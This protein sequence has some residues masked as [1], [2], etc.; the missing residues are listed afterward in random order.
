MNLVYLVIRGV[1]SFLF[2]MVLSLDT[3]VIYVSLLGLCLTCEFLPVQLMPG[4]EV[5]VA[6]KRRK[7]NVNAHEVGYK[8]HYTSTKEYHIAR[9]LLRI[10]AP[11]MRFIHRSNVRGVV[12]GVVLT[13]V[14]Y[15]HS[16]TAKTLSL[17][18]P[19]FVV[20]IPRSS[21]EES[22]KNSDNDA[23]RTKGS[24]TPNLAGTG[25]LA[26]KRKNHQAIVRLLISDSVA[27]GHLMIAKSLRLY[28]GVSLCSCMFFLTSN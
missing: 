6:P 10:Q 28:L 14:A 18:S 20:I 16:E 5:A 23:L 27:K 26:D 8:Q 19:Q 15:I 11:D 17:D 4:T 12:L 22:T 2:Q 13:S 21:S 9:A 1:A 24:S 7:K 3:W 25:T